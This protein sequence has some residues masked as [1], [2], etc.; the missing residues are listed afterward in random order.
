MLWVLFIT[1]IGFEGN[2][3]GRRKKLRLVVCLQN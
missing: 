1:F 3:T 2:T